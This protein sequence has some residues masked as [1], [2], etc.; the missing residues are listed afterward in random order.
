MIV[1]LVFLILAGNTAFVSGCLSTRLRLVLIE[2]YLAY[3]VSELDV[4]F[5]EIGSEYVYSRSI[6]QPSIP[7]VS[8]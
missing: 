3:L 7:H 6:L 5:S 1:M 8:I 2:M 4:V